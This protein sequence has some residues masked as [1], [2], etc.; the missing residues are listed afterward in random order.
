MLHITNVEPDELYLNR[1]I[2]DYNRTNDVDINLEIIIDRKIDI[3]QRIDLEGCF[4]KN[5]S[6]T[7]NEDVK[8]LEVVEANEITIKAKKIRLSST[9]K[10][11]IARNVE[12]LEIAIHGSSYVD[13]SGSTVYS[14]SI[15]GG[16]LSI[17]DSIDF[18]KCESLE[19]TW[20]KLITPLQGISLLKHIELSRCEILDC[21]LNLDID[22]GIN[23]LHQVKGIKKLFIKHRCPSIIDTTVEEIEFDEMDPQ[24]PIYVHMCPLLTKVSIGG[25]VVENIKDI[26]NKIKPSTC[27]FSLTGIPP[28][29]EYSTIR[30]SSSPSIIKNGDGW[31]LI[32]NPLPMSVVREP[33][34]QGTLVNNMTLCNYVLLDRPMHIYELSS[35]ASNDGV[36]D[37]NY[38]DIEFIDYD[39]IDHKLYNGFPIAFIRLNDRIL[40]LIMQYIQ[41]AEKINEWSYIITDSKEIFDI[42]RL[43]NI[44]VYYINK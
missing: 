14:L 26:I 28:T 25:F 33:T 43:R 32:G 9:A 42:C 29:Y 6:I 17:G 23:K 7:C 19:L 41:K 4:T 36:I 2:Q 40:Q 3:K 1:I 27:N 31:E 21:N 8:E 15:S 44:R 34:F 10:S 38:N 11:I 18:S 37:C 30:E 5:L 13:I 12:E 20:T 39:F 22:D 35:V 16:P 24:S